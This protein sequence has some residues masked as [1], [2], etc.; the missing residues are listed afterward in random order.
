MK[1]HELLKL[2]SGCDQE[3]E[4]CLVI[5]KAGETPEFEWTIDEV[6]VC[7]DV[8]TVYLTSVEDA[9]DIPTDT[10]ELSEQRILRHLYEVLLEGPLDVDLLIKQTAKR[11][12][13][14]SNYVLDM[15]GVPSDHGR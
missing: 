10:P 11:A 15:F 1:V 14:H 7:P 9:T 6:T 12:F 2:L 4:V 13:V 3:A 5:A 8:K